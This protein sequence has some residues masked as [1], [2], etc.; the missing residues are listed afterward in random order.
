MIAL[1]LELE[2]GSIMIEAGTG[3]GSLSHALARTVGPSGRLHTF[4]F[5]AHRAQ[6]AA[7]EFEAN[8]LGGRV[9]LGRRRELEPRPLLQHGRRHTPR[10]SDGP[11]IRVQLIERCASH[12]N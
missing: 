4:E 5:N 7:A 2:P 8:N 12:A 6:L 9:G 1:Q 10:S 3:S 11:G